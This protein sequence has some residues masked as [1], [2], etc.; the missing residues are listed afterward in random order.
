MFSTLTVLFLAVLVSLISNYNEWDA[1]GWRV[2]S[3]GASLVIQEYIL[4]LHRF[5]C[6]LIINCIE[7]N[8]LLLKS[9]K[10]M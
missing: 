2:H 4:K 9:V 1:K 6:W 10:T 8:E 3:G 5:C 7:N